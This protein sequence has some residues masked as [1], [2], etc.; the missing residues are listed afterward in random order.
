MD[1]RKILLIEA[2]VANPLATDI[3]LAEIV[4]LNNNTVGRWRK[5]PDFQELLRKRL[6]EQWSDAERL[7]QA[8]MIELAEEKN[9][10]AV[11]YILD[12]LGYAP[13]QR[14]QAD[15]KNE[16]IVINIKKPE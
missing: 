6:Q 14:I 11:K 2:M 1:Q 7:A 12:S 8:K 9:F 4:G 13:A 10:N 16:E 15:V 3:K 5:Q